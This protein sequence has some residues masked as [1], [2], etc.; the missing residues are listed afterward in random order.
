M[1]RMKKRSSRKVAP[2]SYKR[3]LYALLISNGVSA[4]LF[5][6]RSLESGSSRYWFMLWNLFL[7]WLPLLFAWV[8]T[9][10]LQVTRWLSWQNIGLSVLWLGFL[11]NSFYLISDLIHLHETGEVSLLY[12]SVMF[13]SIILNGLIAGFMSMFLLHRSLLRRLGS[14]R[15]YVA[16]NCVLIACSYAIYLGRTL[17]WNTWDVLINPAAL[18]FDITS[19]I[20]EPTANLQSLVTTFIFFVLLSSSYAVIWELV[21][22]LRA[23]NR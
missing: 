18:L 21:R 11:P 19:S 17:R 22:A 8:L 16:M 1:K 3:V 14:L 23:D 4:L 6:L 5:M 9:R 13:M 20:I 10:Q 7:A 12:D 2:P 15:A